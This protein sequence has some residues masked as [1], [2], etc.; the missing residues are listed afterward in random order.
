M[1]PSVPDRLI[2]G[3]FWP[4]NECDR[5]LELALERPVEDGREEGG[6]FDLRF[7]LFHR[8]SIEAKSELIEGNRSP[9]KLA[10]LAQ[11]KLVSMAAWMSR[12]AQDVESF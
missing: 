1:S 11:A 5:P 3:V 7:L 10:Q 12:V 4:S 9:L 6:E 2:S 8:R